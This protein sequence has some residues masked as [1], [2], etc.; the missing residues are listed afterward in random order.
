MMFESYRDPNLT[1]TIDVFN[2]TADFI[3]NIDLS[4]REMRKYIIGTISKMDTP[5]T[6]AMKGSAAIG[7]VISEVTHEDRQRT[8]DE[9]LATTKEDIQ[10]LAEI[11]DACM[12]EDNI[13]VFGNE[14]IVNENA[15]LFEKV[16]K[17]K[18]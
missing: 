13:C 17:S 11:I 2:G 10:N 18:V 1:R 3:K 16:I 8:R 6:P 7:S 5:K 4:E 9:V 15:S 12:K 14:K